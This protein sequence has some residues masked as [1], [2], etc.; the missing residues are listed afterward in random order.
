MQ[1]NCNNQRFNNV[2]SGSNLVRPLSVSDFPESEKL[3]GKLESKL[4]E[5]ENVEVQIKLN[6]K[7]SQI[8]NN[9]Y[10]L[11][12]TPKQ[13]RKTNYINWKYKKYNPFLCLISLYDLEGFFS[14]AITDNPNVSISYILEHEKNCTHSCRKKRFCKLTK[15]T[16]MVQAILEDPKKNSYDWFWYSKN[17]KI[18]LKF[19]SENRN[20]NWNW[21]YILS[22]ATFRDII[23]NPDLPWGMAI[24]QNPNLNFKELLKIRQI[25]RFK[26]LSSSCFDYL[27]SQNSSITMRD[28]LENPDFKWDWSA[29]S[30]YAKVS[31][32]EVLDKGLYRKWDWD[33]LLSN[34]NIAFQE[35]LNYGKRFRSS[36]AL[37]ANPNVPLKHLLKK[38]RNK[39]TLN[40][41]EQTLLL[42]NKFLYDDTTYK[43]KIKNDI[44]KRRKEVIFLSL[45][46]SLNSLV[47]KYVG[48]V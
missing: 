29:L 44:K 4:D 2:S 18:N 26:L 8:K 25:S 10:F 13:V 16:D 47:E 14:C 12:Y 40:H 27:V 34:P 23:D 15:K 36:T 22:S 42:Q 17:P 28:I 41:K 32:K 21:G 19:V 35:L 48:Y 20:L 30:Q 31:L 11:E 5:K 33:L 46:G 6:N 9:K 3:E 39:K 7:D 38:F 43:N 1:S 24:L 45:F 37:L